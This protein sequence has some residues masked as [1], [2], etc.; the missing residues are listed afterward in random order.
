MLFRFFHDENSNSLLDKKNLFGI[1]KEGYGFSNNIRPKF[2]GAN[3]EESQFIVETDTDLT[4][5][6]GY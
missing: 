1:P 3:F 4:I 6:L 2:R 5:N